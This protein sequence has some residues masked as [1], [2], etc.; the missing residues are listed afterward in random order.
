MK[1]AHNRCNR[2]GHEWKDRPGQFAKHRECPACGSV[3]WTWVNYETEW[4]R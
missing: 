2:C 4:R 3:Y 1:L